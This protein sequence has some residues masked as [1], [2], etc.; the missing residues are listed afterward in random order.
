M[1]Y[2]RADVC[3][4]YLCDVKDQKGIAESS[5]FTRGWTLQELLAPTFVHFCDSGWSPIA[6]NYELSAELEAITGISQ[7]ALTKFRHD[8]F[9]IAEKMAWAARRQTTREED[10]AYCLLGLF[11]VNIPLL[12]GE[13]GFKKKS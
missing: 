7:L 6:S 5:W 8:A 3:Y 1:W 11:N 4:A 9:C 12:Y 13:S 2:Q 10:S